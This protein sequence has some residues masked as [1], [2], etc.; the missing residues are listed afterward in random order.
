MGLEFIDGLFNLCEELYGDWNFLWPIFLTWVE[1]TGVLPKIIVGWPEL[2]QVEGFRISIYTLRVLQL[3][4]KPRG[5]PHGTFHILTVA[6][7]NL[8]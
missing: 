5:S 1:W 3:V 6:Y 7:L 2:Q 8:P 4:E